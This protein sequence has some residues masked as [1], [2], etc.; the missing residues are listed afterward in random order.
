MLSMLAILLTSC[1]GPHGPS[2]QAWPTVQPVSHRV[3]IDLHS[4]RIQVDLPI[5]A[6]DGRHVY[7]FACRGGSDRYLDSLPG[8]W[9]GPLMCT[10][11]EG[12]RPSESSLLSEDDS[13]AWYSRGQFRAED[14]VGACGRYPEY[15]RLRT[16]RLRGMR[17]TLEAQ[18]VTGDARAAQS[19]VLVINVTPDPAATTPRADQPGF[20]DPRRPGR[21]CTT[22]LQG[23]D[24]RLCR[25]AKG[26][27]EPC[28]N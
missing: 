18:E 10:L 2:R 8:N 3:A 25:N 14:L 13:A 9:V 28:K 11:A 16:F 20:L 6:T 17:V 15:G 26:S 27:F 19:F 23:R 12:D 7:Y 4:E 5:A 21:S 24:V 1:L 22:V